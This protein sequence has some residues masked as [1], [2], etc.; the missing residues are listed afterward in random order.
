MN[1][2]IIA[3]AGAGKRFGGAGKPKQFLEILGKPVVVHALERFES[4]PQIDEI[5]LVLPAVEIEN[6]SNAAEKYNL[7]KLTKIVA[8]GETRAASVL[9]GF[10]AVDSERTEIVAVHD[11]ARPLVTIDEISK[12]IERARETG[13]AC[14][15]AEVTDTIKEIENGKI[16][17][18]VDR[19]RL[20]RALTPQAFRYEI[21]KRALETSKINETATDESFLVEQSGV[22]VS[23]VEGG[24]Q[25][26]KITR[27]EDLILAE[28]LLKKSQDSSL[29]SQGK[30]QL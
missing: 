17:R 29:K 5:I 1:T 11:G 13:A 25:N 24:A 28:R 3:A 7:K 14:L 20:R 6:F 22:E 2:A 26:I 15:V 19:A 23:T 30:N 21:L 12:T 10:K 9:N 18:T 4:C 27:F 16:A 8:G